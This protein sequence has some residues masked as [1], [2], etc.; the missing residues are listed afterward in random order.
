MKHLAV[1][2]G[3]RDGT[4]GLVQWWEHSPLTNE[5]RV[6]FRFSFTHSW[7]IKLNIWRDISYL[8]ASCIILYLSFS[9]RNVT[10]T[11]FKLRLMIFCETIRAV[12]FT[13]LSSLFTRGKL[14][15]LVS[16]STLCVFLQICF[17]EDHVRRKGLKYTRGQPIPCPKCG[18]E[19]KETKELSMSSKS[20]FLL[21]HGESGY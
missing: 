10:Y 17:C 8:R 18:Y 5:A 16:F 15:L 19:T 9:Q 7:A 21:M 13:F 2:Q 3:S 12:F 1:Q 14:G 20:I 11:N 6:Q 4:A